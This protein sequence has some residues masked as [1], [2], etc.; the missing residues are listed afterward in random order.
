MEA[1]AARSIEVEPDSYALVL[2]LKSE[3]AIETTLDE[4]RNSDTIAWVLD[5]DVGVH[6]VRITEQQIADGGWSWIVSGPAA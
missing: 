5:G 1:A 4:R 3:N 2:C 6:Q